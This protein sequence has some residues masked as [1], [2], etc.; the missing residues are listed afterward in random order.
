M[1][2]SSSVI[3]HAGQWGR[4]ACNEASDILNLSPQ[5]QQYVS[6][7]TSIS[8][9]FLYRQNLQS[10]SAHRHKVIRSSRTRIN[11][12]MC[13]PVNSFL[14]LAREVFDIFMSGINRSHPPSGGSIPR[15]TG[16]VKCHQKGTGVV[17][18]DRLIKKKKKNKKELTLTTS[19]VSPL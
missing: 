7:P 5:L 18:Y 11:L 16:H 10:P 19:R 15:L 12:C 1:A 9:C 13:L 4:S 8:S 17:S 2:W 6:R 14:K 3:L